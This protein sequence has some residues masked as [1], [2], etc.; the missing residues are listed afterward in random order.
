MRVAPLGA[1]YFGN[2]AKAAAEAAAQ[3]EITTPTSR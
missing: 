2:P 1:Y 3:A